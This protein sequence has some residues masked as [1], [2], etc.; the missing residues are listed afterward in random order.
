MDGTSLNFIRIIQ[1]LGKAV[2]VIMSLEIQSVKKSVRVW[3]HKEMDFMLVR[4]VK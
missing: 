2:N 3:K 1:M 4:I